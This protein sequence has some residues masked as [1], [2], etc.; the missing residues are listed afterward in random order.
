[1]Q[2]VNYYWYLAGS[3]AHTEPDLLS[4]VTDPDL[5]GSAKYY[6]DLLDGGAF[7]PMTL[8]FAIED[9]WDVKDFASEYQV[10]LNGLEI[11]VDDKDSLYRVPPGR[12]DIF[13][14][15]SDGFSIADSVEIH[16]LEDKIY[17]VRDV[18]RKRMGIDF[19]DQLMEHPNECTPELD[20]DILTYL[21]IY[22]K[23]HTSSEVYVA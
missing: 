8:A 18:A 4:K 10:F 9:Q 20:G 11:L 15:R 23:L 21:A 13:L 2:N 3:M 16:K 12:V 14:K 6:K 7:A 5:H 1:G 17:F 22:G 19:I